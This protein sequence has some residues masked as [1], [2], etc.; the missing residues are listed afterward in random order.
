ML[1]GRS[2]SPDFINSVIAV[3]IGHDERINSIET[4]YVY[5]FGTRFLVE[6]H[7][8]LDREMRLE[9]SHDISETLQMKIESLPEVERAFVHADYESS[10]RPEEEHLKPS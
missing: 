3:C 2:A 6:V 5:Y 1:T 4:V 10:H 7:I 8:V 9:D